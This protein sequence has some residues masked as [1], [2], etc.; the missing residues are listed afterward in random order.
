MTDNQKSRRGP[1]VRAGAAVGVAG[2][3]AAA[4]A[5]AARTRRWLAQM[6]TPPRELASQH[7][8]RAK[9][10]SAAAAETWRNGHPA[11]QAESVQQ[12]EPVQEVESVQQAESVQEA[13]GVQPTEPHA[14]SPLAS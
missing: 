11:K 9:A 6:D 12:A 2:A 10:A 4:T 3:V 13:E 7:W 8:T 1:L 5:L 14:D